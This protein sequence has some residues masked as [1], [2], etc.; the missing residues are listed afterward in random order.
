[1]KVAAI[2]RV[3]VK[4]TR[5][6]SPAEVE[7]ERQAAL[8]GKL[9][10]ANGER[11]QAARRF[12]I[13]RVLLSRYSGPSTSPHLRAARAAAFARCLRLWHRRG[14]RDGM[15]HCWTRSLLLGAKDGKTPC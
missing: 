2:G 13:R 3:F 4:A 6:L 14:Q 11:R 5:F 15:C 9:T 8:T 10:L 12:H 7:V 1:M